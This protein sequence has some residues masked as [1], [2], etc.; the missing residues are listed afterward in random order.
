MM[1]NK[2]DEP[3]LTVSWIHANRKAG[4]L[5]K[6]EL[7]KSSSL[8]D[9]KICCVDK[10]QN[11]IET[12][13]NSPAHGNKPLDT[14]N[15]SLATKICRTWIAYLRKHSRKAALGVTPNSSSK[16]LQALVGPF[17]RRL[18]HSGHHGGTVLSTTTD[19]N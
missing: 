9:L 16:L 18:T 2:T 7:S 8:S 19:P 14:L 6:L 11:S 1:S 13:K 10:R 4:F 17:E 5:E 3:I 12:F 15:H